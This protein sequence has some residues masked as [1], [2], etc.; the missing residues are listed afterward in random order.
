MSLVLGGLSRVRRCGPTEEVLS[1]DF[2]CVVEFVDCRTEC[3]ALTDQGVRPDGKGLFDEVCTLRSKDGMGRPFTNP[4]R[5]PVP[6]MENLAT[7]LEQSV[8][9]LGPLNMDCR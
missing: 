5:Y 2:A 3:R 9:R 8:L 1:E 6:A 7:P 4:A